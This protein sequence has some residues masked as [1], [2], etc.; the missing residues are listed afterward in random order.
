MLT[1]H[2]HFI[3]AAGYVGP[4]F[5]VDHDISLIIP[6]VWSRIRVA[7]RDPAAMI[8][9]GL[10]EPCSGITGVENVG[11]LGYRITEKF[12]T[13]YFGRVFADPA[14]LFTEPMLRPEQQDLDAF[15]DG[16]SNIV[17]TQR[18]VAQLY[19][20][21]GSID[22]ACPP[23]MA[24]LHVMAHGHHKGHELGSPELRGLF[25]P[26]AMLESDWYRAR[27]AAKAKV[28]ARIWG[29]HLKSLETFAANEIYINEQENLRIP[30]RL[31]LARRRL[32]E[33]QDPAY[34]DRL[35]GTLGTDPAVV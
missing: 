11:R 28:D 34:L 1:R 20:D 19:F 25:D 8:A 31:A 15:I 35:R 14:S 23:L 3:S 13:L 32:G 12:V 30:E 22:D 2:P 21:D 5:R 9:E 29:R 33:V 16:M 4:K 27:L 6:E 18:R 26:D 10:L 7:E 24:L 17:E